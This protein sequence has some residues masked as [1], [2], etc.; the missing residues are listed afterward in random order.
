M[1]ASHCIALITLS[2]ASA[3][4]VALADGAGDA[5][6]HNRQKPTGHSGHRGPKQLMLENAQGAKVV[7]WKPDLT[8]QPLQPHHD[9][10]TLPKTGM[11]NYHALVVEK[12][13]GTSK[14][15]LIR[16]EHMFGRPSKRS[17][18]ELTAADKTEFEIVPTPVPRE[19]YRY[20]SGQ[21]WGF[22]LR[23]H[24]QPLAGQTL[25]L[26]TEHGTRLESVTDDTGYAAF[27]LPDDFPDVV[28]GE[29]DR[30]SAEFIVAAAT[31]AAGVTYQTA[32]SASYHLNPSHWQSQSMGW[33]V[34]GVGFLVGG[35]LGRQQGRGGKSA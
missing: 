12:D 4:P 21:E 27:R 7:L 18:S 14:E 16:Y 1:K 15:T 26:E 22:Q 11:D 9:A 24:G 13:W 25:T 19:H 23:L 35:L 6:A 20:Q 32:L 34:V 3:G 8:S 5:T 2:L 28:A 17:P 30:R 29:R 10:V 33:A 31:D